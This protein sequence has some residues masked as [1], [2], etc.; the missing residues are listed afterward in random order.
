MISDK[1]F[2]YPQKTIVKVAS[3][4]FFIYLQNVVS[5]VKMKKGIFSTSDSICLTD[6]DK[7]RD[8][9]MHERRA[10][11]NE[12]VFVKFISLLIIS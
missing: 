3:D 12:T 9:N 10:I 8:Q 1:F 2:I 7:L 5:D 4:K 11:A 6:D